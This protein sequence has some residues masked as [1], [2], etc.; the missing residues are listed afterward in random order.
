[1][2]RS[3]AKFSKNLVLPRA[4]RENARYLFPHKVYIHTLFRRSMENFPVL[5]SFF[6]DPCLRVFAKLLCHFPVEIKLARVRLIGI[7]MDSSRLEQKYTAQ[8]AP[9]RRSVM[10]DS[11]AQR[12]RLKKAHIPEPKR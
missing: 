4:T 7:W 8:Q 2:L 5:P 12:T 10:A 3:R 9:L 1:M 6:L 11:M